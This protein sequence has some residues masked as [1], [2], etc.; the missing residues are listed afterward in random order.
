MSAESDGV[1]RMAEA[2]CNLYANVVTQVEATKRPIKDAPD[3]VA[4]T[5]TQEGP[6]IEAMLADIK[7]LDARDPDKQI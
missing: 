1:E 5:D 6:S 4:G 3:L 7:V 2:I